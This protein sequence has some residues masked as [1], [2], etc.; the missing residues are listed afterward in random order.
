MCVR[1]SSVAPAQ[2]NGARRRNESSSRWRDYPRPSTSVANG[3]TNWVGDSSSWVSRFE[4]GWQNLLRGGALCE[5]NTGLGQI[6]RALR[7]PVRQGDNID[8][9][10]LA[11]P[12]DITTSADRGQ[13]LGRVR[14]TPGHRARL[15]HHRTTLGL[16]HRPSASSRSTY[17]SPTPGRTGREV[18]SDDCGQSGGHT[19]RRRTWVP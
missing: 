11:D 15:A 16:R 8:H 5:M 4:S 3:E 7:R 9:R 1:E 6:R 14:L 17:A 10:T 18:P 2:S 19:G 13:G 12:V